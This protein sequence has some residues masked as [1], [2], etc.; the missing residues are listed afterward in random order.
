MK[1]ALDTNIISYILRGD[2]GMK[3]RWRK[4]EAVGNQTVI[5]LI[6]YFEV[7]RGLLSAGASTKLAAFEQV[8]AALEV[9]GLTV[10]DMDVASRI[11]SECKRQGRPI[12]DADIL[13]A[14]FCI[15]GGYT[16]VTNNI[17]HF[18][19]IEGLKLD[20]WREDTCCD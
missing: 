15:A 14:A 7:K 18:A 19:N 9:H 17:R 11:Y 8:C 6:V 5:P 12:E 10:R 13:I 4:E 20:N 3:H 1:Y 16:L 2:S